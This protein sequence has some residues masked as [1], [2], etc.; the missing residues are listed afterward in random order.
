MSVRRSNMKPER[1][2]Q[3]ERLYHAALEHKPAERAAFLRQACAGE[4]ALRCEIES[5]LAY[6]EKAEQF[7]ETPALEVAAKRMAEDQT[8]GVPDAFMSEEMAAFIRLKPGEEEDESEIR[9]YCRQGVS[10][11]KIPRYIRFV[12]GFPLTASGQVK[13]F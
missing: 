5:L 6:E 7:I 11:Q 3:I 9:E 13:K 1:W 8:V 12:T 2:Q 10:R 4:D